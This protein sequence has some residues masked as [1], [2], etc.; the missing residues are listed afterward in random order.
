MDP[1]PNRNL[2]SI[3]DM[4]DQSPDTHPIAA[5]AARPLSA[6]QLI[7]SRVWV[8]VDLQA[9]ANNLRAIGDRIRPAQLMLVVKKDAY[10]HGLIPVARAAEETGVGYLGVASV[11]EGVALRA[12]GVTA[13]IVT[14]GLALAEE[15]ESAIAHGID[16]TV[17]SLD[18]ARAIAEVARRLGRLARVHLKVD[19]GMGR[20]G[21]FPEQLLDQVDAMAVLPNLEWVGLYSHLADSAGNPQ[22][23]REQ[24]DRFQRVAEAMKGWLTVRHLGASGAIGDRRLHFDMLR[25]GIAAYGADRDAGDLEPVMAFKSRIVFIKDFPAGRTISYGATYVTSE[26][27]RVG[28]VAA[29]YGNGYP[30]L[31]SNRGHVLVGGCAAPIVGRVCMDQMMVNLNGRPE[32]SVGDSVLLFGRRGG[33]ELPVW[34]VAE[35]AETIAYEVLCCVGTMNPRVYLRSAGA[36]G[37]PATE[38]E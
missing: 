18:D 17:A 6:E 16:L 22:L 11:G 34:K 10:G 35:W 37:K 12:A 33:D 32:A 9:L 7:R 8:E 21:L 3:S 36:G 14:L 13:P 28:V 29:G 20:L 24:V 30:R 2:A 38:S 26:P 4:S 19:T 23:T 31:V 15:I 27:T 1:A 5:G 25:V